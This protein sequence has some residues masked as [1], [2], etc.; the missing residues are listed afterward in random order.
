MHTT[1]GS[2]F[3]YARRPNSLTRL[4]GKI[5]FDAQAGGDPLGNSGYRVLD[6]PLYWNIQRG[7]YP[8]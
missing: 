4:S 2:T 5:T 8:F 6:E 3:L 1:R 7:D